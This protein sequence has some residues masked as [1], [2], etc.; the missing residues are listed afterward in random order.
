MPIDGHVWSLFIY[1]AR[2]IRPS[3][4]GCQSTS[5]GSLSRFV[6]GDERF[7]FI[8][9]HYQD[10]C[11]NESAYNASRRR[12]LIPLSILYLR[13]EVD[14]SVHSRLS[15]RIQMRRV[16]K[17]CLWSAC[18]PSLNTSTSREVDPSVHFLRTMQKTANGSSF[19]FSIVDSQ[20]GG[21]SPLTPLHYTFRDFGFC[22]D[23]WRRIK[24][25]EG[26]C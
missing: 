9:P 4:Q 1:K 25:R 14:P 12:R 3:I 5:A 2:S 18:D 16:Y 15:L 21:P 26:C 24:R 22:L 20:L 11:S 23:A 6:I 10:S 13:R 7:R 19:P 8:R 17:R